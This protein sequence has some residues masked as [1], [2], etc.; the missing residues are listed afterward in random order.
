MDEVNVDAVDIRLEVIELVQLLLV[1][2]PVVMVTPIVDE[3][4]EIG[5]VRAVVPPDVGELVGKAGP[6][7]PLL[8]V[9]QHGVG[10]LN[11][12]RHDGR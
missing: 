7:Q 5:E 11:L 8:Q 3:A 6:R 2:S 9:G 12:E 10:N 1:R 4:L